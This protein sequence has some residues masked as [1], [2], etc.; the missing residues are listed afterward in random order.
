M[1]LQKGLKNN[2]YMKRY[3]KISNRLF[4][5]NR[6]RFVKQLK[7]NSIAIFNS[8]DEMPY[9]GDTNFPFRQNSDIFYLS[10]IDQEKSVLIIFPDAKK[11]EYREALFLRKTNEKIQVWEG[12]KYS[13]EEAKEISG[14]ES[15]Y[16]LD[17]FEA[18]FKEMM[19]QARYCYL[20]INENNRFSSEVAYRDLRI[21]KELKEKFPAHEFERC[22]PIMAELR[23][24][25][26][27]IEIELIK[28]ACKI[29]QNAF[30]RVLN[31][32]HPGI[33]EFEIEAE[34]THEFVINRCEH[35]YTPIV[36]SGKNACVLHYIENNSQ[37]KENEI[38]LLDFGAQYA[39]YAADL[40]R[41]IPVN[42]VFTKRQKKIYNS[43]RQVQ[44]EAI[45][46]LRPGTIIEDYQ[47]EVGKM[48]ESELIGL[49]LLNKEEVAKQ[50]PKEPLYKKYF[51]HGTSHH[52]G[53]DVHDIG[54]RSKPLQPGMVLTCEPGIYIPE[55]NT[56][57]R[58]E[59]D[60]LVTDGNPL[61]LM[62]DIPIE[63]EEIEEIM[64][65]N[66]VAV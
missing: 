37:C 50:N 26:S 27:S 40:S 25:K 16:W 66:R 22:G 13:K 64:S 57:I 12:H 34:V 45:Q 49:G 11:P 48:M 62:Q 47:K 33:Y 61:D 23:A 3:E 51:M 9:S 58:I 63:A 31:F 15:V 54:D 38:I 46:M 5:E 39:N 6:K 21:A 56:G 18:I 59:N 29:T 36:A 43:V 4:T 65:K 2:I 24:I 32:V 35:A 20:N 10:G 42:G 60:I 8:N 52:L 28:Q 53:L 7:P 30:N 41:T 14:I 44:K 19:H 55:E 17:E 1:I